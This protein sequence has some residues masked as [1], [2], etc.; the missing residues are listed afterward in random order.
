MSLLGMSTQGHDFIILSALAPT[1]PCVTT[2]LDL[3]ITEFTSGKVTVV[4]LLAF[5][6][7]NRS[8][9]FTASALDDTETMSFDHGGT[10]SPTHPRHFLP[11]MTMMTLLHQK[12]THGILRTL[13][14]G[15]RLSDNGFGVTDSLLRIWK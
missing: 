6:T 4:I 11:S 15:V 1:S 9:V 14:I 7:M 13:H 10:R 12:D 2:F 5:T 8:P 3:G